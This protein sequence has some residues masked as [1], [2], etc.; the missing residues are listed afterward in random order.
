MTKPTDKVV[1][2]GERKSIVAIATQPAAVTGDSLPAVIILNTGIIHRV[3]HN[4]MYVTL[5][6]ELAEM[7]H[8]VLRLDLSGIG[9]SEARTDLLDPLAA[10]LADIKDAID[11]L[12]SARGAKSVVLL[13]LCSGADHSIVYAG[14]D[15]RVVGVVLLDPSV[16]PTPLY[17]LKHF[18]SKL[19]RGQNWKNFLRGRGRIWRPFTRRSPKAASEEWSP[20]QVSFKDPQVRAY[21]ENAYGKAVQGGNQLLAIFTAGLEHQHNYRRQLLDAMRNVRFGN[22]LRLEYFASCDHTFTFA[23]DRQRLFSMV[24][25]WLQTTTFV[26]PGAAR[27]SNP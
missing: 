6:R 10:C 22:K 11:W 5:S 12:V 16:P 27:R 19:L 26:D 17:Y 20:R 24:K 14:S 13:G 15:P 3:G 21:V 1:L 23:A 9:D 7:G 18:G 2:L 25:A 8:V 4:R